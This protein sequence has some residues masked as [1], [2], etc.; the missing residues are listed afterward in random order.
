MITTAERS[1]RK[2]W[3]MRAPADVD[4]ALENIRKIEH[5]KKNALMVSLVLRG[6]RDWQREKRARDLLDRSGLTV[7]SILPY[8]GGGRKG[9]QY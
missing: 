8:I 6:I 4:D 7:E 3:L 9:K 1:E 5:M 2:P